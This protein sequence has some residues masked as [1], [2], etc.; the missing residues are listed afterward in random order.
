[1]QWISSPW[2]LWPKNSIEI[3]PKFDCQP[4]FFIL[5]FILIAVLQLPILINLLLYFLTTITIS[6]KQK[7]SKWQKRNE[8]MKFFERE[9]KLFNIIILNNKIL[10]SIVHNNH[11]ESRKNIPSMKQIWNNNFTTTIIYQNILQLFYI[12]DDNFMW[13]MKK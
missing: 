12:L 3:L 4:M 1:M 8:W 6:S 2:A 10:Y 7:N 11:I 5:F 9:N 13:K